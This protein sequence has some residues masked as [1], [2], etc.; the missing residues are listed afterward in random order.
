[1]KP[2]STGSLR[3]RGVA[4]PDLPTRSSQHTNCEMTATPK[5]E[6]SFAMMRRL[7]EFQISEFEI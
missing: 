1:V 2:L 6:R 5:D 7:L 3:F 4:S